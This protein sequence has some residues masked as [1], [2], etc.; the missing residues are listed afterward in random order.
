VYQGVLG[1]VAGL[2][3]PETG[4]PNSPVVVSD[5]LNWAGI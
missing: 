2:S 3:P 4:L 5:G 1:G